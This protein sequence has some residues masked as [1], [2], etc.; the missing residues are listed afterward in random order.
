MKRA[1]VVRQPGS[2]PASPSGDSIGREISDRLRTDRAA[3]HLL[4]EEN[5]RLLRELAKRTTKNRVDHDALR[6][7][8]VELLVTIVT[9]ISS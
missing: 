1:L 2:D 4:G 5:R 7:V 9:R 8:H 3:V 6:R